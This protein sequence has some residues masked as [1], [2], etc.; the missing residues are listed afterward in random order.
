MNG[1]LYREIKGFYLPF[2]VVATLF[3]PRRPAFPRAGRFIASGGAMHEIDVQR[4]VI[5]PL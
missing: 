2:M 3:A 5:D 1:V 4:V